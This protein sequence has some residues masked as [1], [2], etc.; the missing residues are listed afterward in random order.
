MTTTDRDRTD[1]GLPAL[2]VPGHYCRDGWL[3]TDEHPRPCPICRPHLDRTQD[4]AGMTAWR[5]RTTK[6]AHR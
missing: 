4:R 5:A 6:E 1:L 2:T 3:G